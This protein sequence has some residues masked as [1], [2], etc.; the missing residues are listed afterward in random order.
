MEAEL[1][2]DATFAIALASSADQHHDRAVELARAVEAR[3]ARLVTTA[4]VVLEIGNALSRLRYRAAALTLLDS[5]HRDPSIDVVPLS[6][7][8]YQRALSLYR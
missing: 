2:L 7:P 6:E 3:Q 4:A 8:L 1:F 5:L